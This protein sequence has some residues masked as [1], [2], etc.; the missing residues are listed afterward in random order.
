MA[1]SKNWLFPQEEK[2]VPAKRLQSPVPRGEG[3][4]R[5]RFCSLAAGEPPDCEFKTRVILDHEFQPT[6]KR[7]DVCGTPANRIKREKRK[8]PT[9]LLW[10]RKQHKSTCTKCLMIESW[11]EF[12]RA[13]A[14]GEDTVA[15]QSLPARYFI[16]NSFKKLQSAERTAAAPAG[17]RDLW[18]GISCVCSLDPRTMENSP[19]NSVSRV[20]NTIK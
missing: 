14:I 3:G 7:S 19:F 13:A 11:G 2:G 16:R 20:E 12:L 15:T 8:L 4:R 17:S 1:H 6:K 10:R 9:S 18:V 5:P